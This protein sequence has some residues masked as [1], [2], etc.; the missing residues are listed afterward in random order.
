MKSTNS[1]KKNIV[2]VDKC[3][4]ETISGSKKIEERKLGKLLKKNEK[5]RHPYLFRTFTSWQKPSNDYGNLE[6]MHEPRYSGLDN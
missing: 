3:L 5:R 6:R 1:A 4:E 2:V